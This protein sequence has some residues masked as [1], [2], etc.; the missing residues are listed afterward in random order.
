MKW[1]RTTLGGLAS[2][3]R[4]LWLRYTLDLFPELVV[5][6]VDGR[7]VT[8]CFLSAAREHAEDREPAGDSGLSAGAEERL[9]ERR[10]AALCLSRGGER[11]PRA[12]GLGVCLFRDGKKLSIFNP[13]ELALLPRISEGDVVQL[14][15][16]LNGKQCF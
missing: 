12:A 15:N 14:D 2:A 16:I 3:R 6:S 7:L 1:T 10:A 8:D 11:E 5:Y 9:D 13:V 4:R